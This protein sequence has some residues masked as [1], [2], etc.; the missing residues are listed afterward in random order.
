MEQGYWALEKGLAALGGLAKCAP[1]RSFVSGAMN[2]T[3][4]RPQAANPKEYCHA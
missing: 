3:D 1:A 2:E 4:A